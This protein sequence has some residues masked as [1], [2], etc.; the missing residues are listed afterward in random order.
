MLIHCNPECLIWKMNNWKK[1]VDLPFTYNWSIPSITHMFSIVH[2]PVNS[3]GDSEDINHPSS[4][5][6]ELI[7]FS[8]QN[9]FRIFRGVGGADGSD[10]GRPKLVTFS[11]GKLWKNPERSLI[12]YS[13]LWLTRE[14]YFYSTV[15]YFTGWSRHFSFFFCSFLTQIEYSSSAL[16]VLTE[17]IMYVYKSALYSICASIVGI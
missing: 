10:S 2:V 11:Y 9:I 4:V 15:E 6:F 17:F 8:T 12:N 3:G 1:Y 13:A 14:V 16:A 5:V 7:F